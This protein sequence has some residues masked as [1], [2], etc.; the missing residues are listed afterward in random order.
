M[1]SYRIFVAENSLFFSVDFIVHS[2]SRVPGIFTR[3][4]VIATA[5]IFVCPSEKFTIELSALRFGRLCH[6]ASD[7]LF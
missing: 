5:F 2:E 3:G 1:D 6:R 4:T 7:G